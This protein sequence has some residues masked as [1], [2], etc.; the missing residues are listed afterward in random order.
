MASDTKEVINLNKNW[1]RN[2]ESLIGIAD[3]FTADD[4]LPVPAV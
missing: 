2:D 4:M 3:E 1:R